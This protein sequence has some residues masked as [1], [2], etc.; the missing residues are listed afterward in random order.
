MTLFA[1]ILKVTSLKQDLYRRHQLYISVFMFFFV[2]FYINV[3]SKVSF[4]PSNVLPGSLGL[5]GRCRDHIPYQ[6]TEYFSCSLDVCI[7]LF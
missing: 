3:K 5:S 1:A 4:S 6:A 7:V 2:F